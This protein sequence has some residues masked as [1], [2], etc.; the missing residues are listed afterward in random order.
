MR[1]VERIHYAPRSAASYEAPLDIL[2]P[3]L[4]KLRAC[5]NSLKTLVLID[6]LPEMLLPALAWAATQKR[7][8]PSVAVE[9]VVKACGPLFLERCLGRNRARDLKARYAER[10]SSM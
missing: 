5:D 4:A 9:T 1:A 2:I 10:K 6:S 3:A 8:I 7:F